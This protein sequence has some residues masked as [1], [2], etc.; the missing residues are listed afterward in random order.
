MQVAAGSL[1]FRLVRIID[2]GAGNNELYCLE[3]VDLRGQGFF[4]VDFDSPNPHH[5]FSASPIVRQPYEYGICHDHARD[6]CTFPVDIVHPSLR[7]RRHVVLF[8]HN[9][10]LWSIGC[11]Q[12]V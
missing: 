4:C 2:S 12:G 5:C 3:E 8:R 6:R 10:G 1:G 7:K 9:V 11:L